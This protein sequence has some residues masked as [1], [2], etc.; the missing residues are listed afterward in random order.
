M[1]T[2][3]TDQAAAAGVVGWLDLGGAWV[4]CF[5]AEQ[6]DEAALWRLQQEVLKAGAREGRLLPTG[7]RPEDEAAR[8]PGRPAYLL[9]EA[10]EGDS[11]PKATTREA[12]GWILLE[13]EGQW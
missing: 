12:V 2:N 3:D 9:L 8:R 6:P 7:R 11:P 1:S 13:G 4:K 10:G 5:S